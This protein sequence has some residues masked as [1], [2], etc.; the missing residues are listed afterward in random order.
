MVLGLLI[1]P[2][3]ATSTGSIFGQ[4]LDKRTVCVTTCSLFQG[5]YTA[6]AFVKSRNY[7]SGVTQSD[8]ERCFMLLCEVALGKSE[9]ISDESDEQDEPL[10]FNEYQSRKGHGS[11]I[12]DP[13]YM[14]KR[15]DGL[16][17]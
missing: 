2:L 13:R 9:E 8:G 3:C 11:S 4:V 6:D 15:N 14:I 17:H 7:C 5:I 16:F 1:A 10:D 12:P